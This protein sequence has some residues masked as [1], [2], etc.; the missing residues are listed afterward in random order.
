MP[1]WKYPVNIL[2]L[3]ACCTEATMLEPT[4]NWCLV[5]CSR[6]TPILMDSITC[7]VVGGEIT[8]HFTMPMTDNI[9]RWQL[10]FYFYSKDMRVA[11]TLACS[12]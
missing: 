5:A 10:V 9:V 2:Q 3:Q 7:C 4:D 6:L 12:S 8:L 11:S 1:R